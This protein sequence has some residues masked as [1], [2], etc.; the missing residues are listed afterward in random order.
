MGTTTPNYGLTKPAPTDRVDI[1]ILDADL[2][3]ID[4]ALAANATASAGT[5]LNPKAYG[6]VGDGVADDTAALQAFVTALTGSFGTPSLGVVPAGTYKITSPITIG[7]S[8]FFTLRGYGAFVIQATDNTP[9]FRF[10][11]ENSH[12]F[13]I[14]GFAFKWANNQNSGHTASI[15]ISFDQTSGTTGAGW[16][17]FV[18]RDCYLNNGYSLVSQGPATTNCVVWGVVIDRVVG[19]THVI[20]PL[21]SLA[22]VVGGQPEISISNFYMRRDNAVHPGLVISN[23]NCVALRNIEFNNGDGCCLDISNSSGVTI[24]G[25]RV[26]GGTL[27]VS[28]GTFFKFSNTDATIVSAM[29]QVPVINVP[30]SHAFI[31]DIRGN[32]MVRIENF[33]QTGGTLTSGGY[34]VI[35]A[36]GSSPAINVDVKHW[37]IPSWVDV[38]YR[39]DS[40]LSSNYINVDSPKVI[41]IDPFM[42]GAPDVNWDTIAVDVD[43]IHNGYKAT[44]SAAQNNAISFPFNLCIGTWSLEIMYVQKTDGGI[45]DVQVDGSSVGTVDM[46]AATLTHN[47]RTVLSGIRFKVPGKHTLKLLMSTKNSSSS[48]YGGYVQAIRFLRTG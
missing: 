5:I 8:A 26:E 13:E 45:A 46:H 29:V 23:A 38:C 47:T 3:I 27:T 44:D 20:G 12:N 37:V 17:N 30:G 11:T 1:T 7:H 18:I 6:A 40:P 21:V 33:N 4:T 43:C 25:L 10:T 28:M 14:S 22:N 24:D 39:Y 2:D 32:S 36:G 16:Y 48:A 42:A 15:C 35:Y 31:F 9:I 41:S 19:D 34:Y